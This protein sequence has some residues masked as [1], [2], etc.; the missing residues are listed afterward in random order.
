MANVQRTAAYVVL[1]ADDDIS[2]RVL[3]A[4][5]LRDC[6][7]EVLE[8]SSGD[9]AMRVLISRVIDLLIFDARLPGEVGGFALADRVRREH[10]HVKVALTSGAHVRAQ[11]GGRIL[12]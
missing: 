7:Y 8:V 12:H 2:T 11:G 1:I 5:H 6:G 9:E 3:L 10:P 4:E